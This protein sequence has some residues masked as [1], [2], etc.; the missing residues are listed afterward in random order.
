MAPY[1]KKLAEIKEAGTLKEYEK[2]V[3]AQAK[4]EKDVAAEKGAEN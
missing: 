3:R 2:Q 4:F 1:N